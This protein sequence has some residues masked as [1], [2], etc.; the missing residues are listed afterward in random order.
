[1]T[2]LMYVYI[3]RIVWALI[4][5]CILAFGF[6]R[7]WKAE[8]GE[9]K[10]WWM[11]EREDTVVGFDPI[12]FP[13]MLAV[14]AFTYYW[15]FGPYE[16][17]QFI[18]YLAIDIFLFISIY[19]TLL[20]VFLPV[21]RKHYTA[22]ACATFWLIPLFLFYQP[23][24]L[25]NITTVPKTVFYVPGRVMRV[26]VLVWLAGF[27]MI[28]L[29]QIISHIW[30]AWKLKRHSYPVEDRKL[31]EQWDCLKEE[32]NLNFPI[33]LRYCSLVN[34]PLTVG[35]WKKHRITYLPVQSYADEDA[36]LILSHELRHIQ[37]NDTHTKFFLRF[38]NALGWIHPFVWMGVRKAEDDL[39]LSCDE[40]VLKDAGPARRRKYAELLLT[41]AGNSCGFTTCLSASA[42]TL[43]YRMKATYCEKKKRL[44][45][46]LLF[47][48][49][50]ASVFCAGLISISTDREKIGNVLQFE[51]DGI[52]QAGFTSERSRGP[53]AQ[54]KDTDALAEY[55][56]GLRAERMLYKYNQLLGSA[57]PVLSGEVNGV[58]QFYIFDD[59]ME[60]R[61]PKSR[62]S[63][64]YHLTDPVDWEYIRSLSAA[65]EESLI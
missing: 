28:F 45:T 23:Q 62:N 57:E 33:G 38:C 9:K 46:L 49:M 22:K 3:Y 61:F 26:L 44:G 19:Y 55:L 60:V 24:M 36:E 11:T 10:S 6:R 32:M 25:Y 58:T 5:G 35:M 64:L 51:P 17:S 21:L 4:L 54:I 53:Y 8:R 7:S 27:I 13:I 65:A 34:T 31:T 30:F 47:I 56:S 20:L 40:I 37:R 63:T 39:E 43:R 1:M 14:F 50:T 59:Y 12:I 2:D 16:G 29:A 42:R 15:I 48:V 18:L 52:S 41:T